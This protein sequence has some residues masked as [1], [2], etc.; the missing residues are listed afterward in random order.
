MN[1]HK[2]LIALLST[3]LL[4]VSPLASAKEA[5]APN[6][7]DFVNAYIKLF[8]P[9]HM[10]RAVDRRCLIEEPEL[11]PRSAILTWEDINSVGKLEGASAKLMTHSA[12]WK[13]LRPLLDAKIAETIETDTKSMDCKDFKATIEKGGFQVLKSS[14]DDY[15]AVMKGFSAMLKEAR[16]AGG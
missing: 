6:A 11:V 3:S 10:V 12:D 2:I 5:A 14:L 13:A 15:L 1:R 16:A 4:I 8:V 7:D 9:I